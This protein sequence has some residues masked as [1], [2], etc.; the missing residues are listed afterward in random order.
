MIILS[1]CY[2]KQRRIMLAETAQTVFNNSMSL[3]LK[4]QGI[5]LDEVGIVIFN[6]IKSIQT[7]N[8]WRKTHD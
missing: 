6:S 8:K 4:I 5:N 7:I 3:D 2:Y 1:P